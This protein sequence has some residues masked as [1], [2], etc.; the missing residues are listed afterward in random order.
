[1]KSE[2]GDKER[3][4]RIDDSGDRYGNI[5]ISGGTVGAIGGRG[6]HIEQAPARAGDA[7]P[8]PAGPSPDA[9]PATQRYDLAAVRDLLL[10]AFTA[11]DLRRLFE[12]SAHPELKGV[13]QE[14]AEGD[15]LADMADKVIAFC[16]T[17]D[18]LSDLLAEVARVRPRP[19]ARYK[20]GGSG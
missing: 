16:R 3:E 12:Y 10:D 5:T 2:G 8:E 14:F 7:P 15:G 20:Q 9:A 19:Y 13:A 18:L 11:V 1:M 4:T 17:R 6:H